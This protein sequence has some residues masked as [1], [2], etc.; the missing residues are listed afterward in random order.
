MWFLVNLFCYAILAIPLFQYLLHNRTAWLARVFPLIALALLLANALLVK[1]YGAAIGGYVTWHTITYAI[2]YALGFWLMVIPQPV[3][4]RLQSTRFTTLALGIALVIYLGLLL[5]FAQKTDDGYNLMTDGY[6]ALFNTPWLSISHSSYALLYALATLI[7]CATMFG[8]AHRHLNHPHRRLPTLN[9][10]V[11]PLYI[12]H[13]IFIFVGLY[14][15][16]SM[17]WQWFTEFL[18]LTLGTFIGTAI[19]VFTYDRILF[20]RPLV[21]LS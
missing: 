2:Y 14:Y 18:I 11:Y 8:F 21:G 13:M 17:S 7:W 6:W 9:R 10:A 4:E 20:M 16:R 1:P 5:P 12:F 15:L 19:L 3:W